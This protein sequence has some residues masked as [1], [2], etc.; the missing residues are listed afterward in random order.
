MAYYQQ[1]LDRNQ[2]RNAEYLARY[3]GRARDAIE[4]IK[5]FELANVQRVDDGTYTASSMGYNGQVEVE[6]EIG[7]HKITR[8]R[9][10]KHQEKQFYAAL[11]DT[12]RQ[13]LARQGI[14]DVDGTSGATI[15]S[16]AI[17]ASTAK[18][19]ARGAK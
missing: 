18:A 12:P 13:I 14:Q 3:Q 7:S 9:V 15:T 19:M 2:A 10:T 17:I 4:A 6:V 8:V 5:S 16:Q 1:V 11:T